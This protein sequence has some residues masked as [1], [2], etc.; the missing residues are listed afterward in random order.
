VNLMSDKVTLM[1]GGPAGSGV[2]NAGLNM[3]AKSCLRSGLK[4][5][6]KAE[7]PSLIRGGH[8]YL[9]VTVDT[10]DV[11]SHSNE[12]NLLIAL[13]KKTVEMHLD[14]VK[15][16][17][18]YDSTMDVEIPENV[19]AFSIPLK[20]ASEKLGSEI[21]QNTIAIGAALGL[22]GLGLEELEKIIRENFFHKGEKVVNANIKAAHA[23]YS[24]SKD[25]KYPYKLSKQNFDDRILLNGNDAIVAGA[26]KAGCKFISAYPMT[27]ATSVLTGMAKFSRDFGIVVKHTEDEIA[28]INMAI[29]AGFVGT[30]AMTC[31]SGGGFALMAEGLGLSAQAEVPVVIIESQRPGPGSGMATRTGQGDLN[32][33]LNASTDEFPRVVIAPGDVNECFYL[34]QQ[35]FNIAEKYQMPVIILVDKFLSTSCSSVHKFNKEMKVDRGKIVVNPENYKR[36]EVTKDG[37]SARALPGTMG[38]E[39]VTSS[40]EHDEKGVEDETR[41]NR[42]KMHDKRYRKF[43]TL[44]KELSEPELKGDGDF[45]VVSWG[46]TKGIV[47]EAEKILKQENSDFTHLHLSFLSPFCKSVFEKLKGKK[48]IV[49]ENNKTSQLS[50]LILKE[51]G[52]VVNHKVLK[53]DGRQFDPEDLAEGLRDVIATG[54]EEIIINGD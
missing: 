33:M 11:Y 41:E 29:G 28:S 39:H 12:I 5:F 45:V 9:T 25:K 36:Y 19:L 18:I 24:L 16:G 42:I 31:T 6:T 7:Y 38:G 13:D 15:G 1:I 54:N 22:L 48:L 8:N 47:R 30:R 20:E 37:I 32:F 51:T 3:F 14:D 17:V 23:G 43:K 50:Q 40:Y 21:Y 44:E 2:L 4:V 35:A 27:P 26:V 52:I 53:Y 10:E 46:S 49:V 34:T